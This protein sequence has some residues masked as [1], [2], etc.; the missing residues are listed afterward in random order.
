MS[1]AWAT[2]VLAIDREMMRDVIADLNPENIE[3]SLGG[4][5]LLLDGTAP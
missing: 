4:F 1:L 3:E 5:P 2:N